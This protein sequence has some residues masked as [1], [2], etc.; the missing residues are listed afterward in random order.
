MSIRGNGTIGMPT[1][2]FHE[3]EG[4]VVTVET[5]AGY[6]YRGTVVSAEDTMNVAMREV[7][8]MG[9]DGAVTRM[10]RVFIRGSQL[11]FMV[12]PDAMLRAPFFTR[13]ALASRGITVASGLGRGRQA[14]IGAKGA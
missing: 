5:K 14:A 13:V 2:L 9:P 3:S 11:L 12:F 4:L 6:S 7:V 1:V 10:D 8:V